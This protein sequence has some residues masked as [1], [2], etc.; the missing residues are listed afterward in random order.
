MTPWSWTSSL[1]TREKQASGESPSLWLSATAS[2]ASDTPGSFRNGI[3][4]SICPVTSP[5]KQ[6]T[7]R[8]H[9]AIQC[10]RH[11]G[12]HGRE[13]D[14]RAVGGQGAFLGPRRLSRQKGRRRVCR[15]ARAR[16]ETDGRFPTDTDLIR[17]NRNNYKGDSVR[18]CRFCRPHAP[19]FSGSG[20]PWRSRERG[21][22]APPAVS[23]AALGREDA[24]TERRWLVAR[25]PGG[26]LCQPGSPRSAALREAA[27]TGQK[28]HLPPGETR[29]S[30][31]RFMRT[32]GKQAPEPPRQKA[33]GPGLLGAGWR[34]AALGGQRQRQMSLSPLR[35]GPSVG[36]ASPH[37]WNPHL[38]R[39]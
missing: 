12:R 28:P 10:L 32:M 4:S 13:V 16:T 29:H 7:L 2:L 25:V 36:E 33:P 31:V 18:V 35:G 1:L 26:G 27:R 8:G 6:L 34:A 17:N 39:A 15:P 38:E 19:A 14:G 21:R 11:R 30:A 20:P 37:H 9:H 22:A 5:E 23:A 3:L 24:D